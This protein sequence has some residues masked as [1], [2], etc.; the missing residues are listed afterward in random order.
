MYIITL[1]YGAAAPLSLN[2][3]VTEKSVMQSLRAFPLKASKT[4]SDGGP[5]QHA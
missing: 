1:H 2:P 4:Q 5:I 3:P